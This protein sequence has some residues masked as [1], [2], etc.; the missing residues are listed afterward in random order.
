M[1]AQKGESAPKELREAKVAIATL[2]GRAKDPMTVRFPG[3]SESRYLVV[4]EKIHPTPEKYPRRIGIP[5]KR[6]LD[7]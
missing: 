6:P 7:K 4:I 2:G 1:L 3:I 5:S